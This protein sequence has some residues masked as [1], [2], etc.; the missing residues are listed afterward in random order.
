MISSTCLRRL[1]LLS[2]DATVCPPTAS[3]NL[4]FTPRASCFSTTSAR[5][6]AAKRPAVKPPKRGEKT[7]NVKKG[8]KAPTQDSKPRMAPGEARQQRKKIVLSNN[9]ALE[10]RSLEDLDRSNVL[11]AENLGQVKGIP[12]EAVD[13]LRAVDAFKPRQGWSLFW[14]PAMLMRKE[15]L[16]LAELIKEVE[17]AAKQNTNKT[18]RNVLVGERM[19]GKSTLVLQGITMAFLRNWTII[20]LPDGMIMLLNFNN[21][22]ST[23]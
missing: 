11:R 7:L 23:C 2:L 16:Q 19:S 14:R 4:I 6:A 17:Q 22:S 9:N 21:H 18:I 8:R 10:V 20:N 12:E 13:A 1:S 15:T 5:Y 3:R